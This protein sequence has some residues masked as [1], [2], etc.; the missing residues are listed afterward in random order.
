MFNISIDITKRYATTIEAENAVKLKELDKISQTM[1]EDIIDNFD[2]EF[3][4]IIDNDPELRKMNDLPFYELNENKR[5]CNFCLVKKV[6][7]LY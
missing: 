5:F 6:K 1:C 3:H 7:K 2:I 4:R